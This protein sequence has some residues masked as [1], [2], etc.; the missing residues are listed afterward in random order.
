MPALP[1]F[2]LATASSF[3]ENI[4]VRLRQSAAL[5]AAAATAVLAFPAVAVAETADT[6]Y[7][8]NTAVNCAENGSG[9][10]AQPFCSISAAANAVLPGQTVR[11]APG[12]TYRETVTFTRSGTPDKPITFLGL[13]P[14][15][16][17]FVRSVVNTKG[18]FVLSN[19]HDVVLRGFQLYGWAGATPPVV[20]VADSSRVTLDRIRYGLTGPTA[21]RISGSS[22]HVTVSRN[23]FPRTG[24]VS[25]GAGVH[26]SLITGNDFNQTLSAAIT[27]TDAP[28]LAVTG[29]TIA[30]S[31][32]ESVKIDGVSPGALVE[33]NVI[34]AQRG[35]QSPSS[36]C[37]TT[38]ANR[39]E[40]EISLS[41][42]STAGS[43]VDYNTVHPWADAS[44]YTW[45]S[46]SYPNA[47]AF[48]S[49]TR[50]AGHDADL[51]LHP[52][53]AYYGDDHL[54]A[55]ATAAIDSADPTAP[56]VDTD[57]LGI[58]PGDDP[59][60]PNTVAGGIRDRG[61]YE[62]T[63][64]RS[65]VVTATSDLSSLQGP[66]PYTVK[67]TANVVNDFGTAQVGYRFDFG[68]GSGLVDS[69]EPT[70][71]HVFTKPGTY[72][73]SVT[74]TDAQ[75]AQVVSSGSQG[76]V[77]KEPGD[78][79]AD[80]AIQ[81]NNDFLQI[82][83]T[84][85]VSSP[86]MITKQDV[87][88]GDGAHV[89]YPAGTI[90]SHQYSVPGTYPVT[91]TAVDE[92]GRTVVIKKNV[93]VANPNYLAALQ[94]G[95]RVQLLGQSTDGELLN[96]GANYTSKV[97]APFLPVRA[98]GV[99]FAAKDVSSVATATT[100]DQY[101]RAF[102]LVKG[103]IY[104]AD[105][106]LGPA[107]GG[108]A[109]GQWLP[110]KE[111]SGMGTLS[112][113]T[114]ISAASIG[115]STHLVAVANGRVYES[116]AD[117]TSG[118]WSAWGDVTGVTGIPVGVK[119]IAAGTTGNALHIAIL[120]SDGH[121]RVA[122]GDYNRGRWSYGD[123]TA[124]YGSPAGMTQV[125]AASTPGSR[126]HVVVLANGRIHET[127]GDYAQGYW[128]GWGDISAVSGFGGQYMYGPVDQ[129][130]AAST[131]NTIRVFGRTEYGSVLGVSGDYTAGQWSGTSVVTEM[132]GGQVLLLAAAGL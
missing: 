84:P 22:D 40:T 4:T 67:V 97:W 94:P 44:A 46:A 11:I 86:Y 61:A 108:V 92:G 113:I 60:V 53:D 76:I 120:G 48:N 106:N 91:L 75:G 50:Q 19:V 41:A 49:A 20:S 37:A 127:T 71:T 36:A 47:A 43:K 109:Q 17:T 42:A 68:D 62:L 8:D 34:T 110:W 13:T 65:A 52:G 95:Q 128:T 119:S 115:N 121:L 80:L 90:A 51:D 54:T 30:Y 15:T 58:K 18:T 29:N 102:V 26:D 14:G 5:T 114:Q 118:T 57:V 131:G 87:D 81:V 23:L 88:F 103:K 82:V 132:I 99:S 111:V 7:V 64:Q 78:L 55:A 21:V 107:S 117:R 66:A 33:N 89:S 56:G 112:G 126:F 105:R 129:I 83:A 73:P 123:V 31:C 2:R 74:A 25:V 16:G 104:N 9:T 28:G 12:T 38:A 39:G 116:S 72:Y 101:L 100:A 130:A 77:V 3:L 98:G 10:A 122:D 59:N 85:T 45:G 35:N 79:T 6:I 125:A 69:T 27:A 70:V 124:A 1:R 93:E 32:M 24:G 96:S 63:G